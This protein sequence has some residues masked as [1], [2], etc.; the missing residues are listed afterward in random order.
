MCAVVFSANVFA[1]DISG[2]VN[3]STLPDS[4]EI[5]LVG[6]T[7]IYMDVDK[8]L[9]SIQA[10]FPLVV[11]GDNTLSLYN[12]TEDAIFSEGDVNISGGNINVKSFV[13]PIHSL[14]GDI[15]LNGNI[16]VSA[17]GGNQN[18]VFAPE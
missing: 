1:I 17:S 2:T 10:D 13:V 9:K 14:K 18:L 5:V 8:T 7:N 4:A 15:S 11:S 6:N 16:T 3:A 12:K